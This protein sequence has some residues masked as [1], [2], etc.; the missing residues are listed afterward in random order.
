[1]SDEL[2]T[3]LKHADPVDPDEIRDRPVP[4]EP[5]ERIMA[6]ETDPRKRSRPRVARLVPATAAGAAAIA[7]AAAVLPGG[8]SDT[9]APGAQRALESVAAVAAAHAAPAT[10]GFLYHRLRRAD[11]GAA[12]EPPHPF[13]YRVPVTIEQWAG[14]DGSGRVRTVAHGPELVGPRDA[15]NWRRQGSPPLGSQPSSDERFGPG[16]LDGVGD[17]GGLP[18]TRE[19]PADAGRLA[20]IFRAQAERTDVPV[21]VKTFEYA[22]SVLLQAGSSPDLRAALYEMVAGID[23]VQLAG[24]ARDPLGRTGTGVSIESD[25]S[26]APTRETLIFDPDTSQPLARV[27][28]LLEPQD[29]IEGRLLGYSVLEQSGRVGSVEARP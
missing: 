28:R 25:Y 2:L 18:P 8:G 20:E 24:R 12:P 11:V 5:L 19:L 27:E 7:V 4:R 22:A 10:D 17:E 6:T 29:W 16:G 9:A 3:L 23:G 14:A 26:G 13:A 1:M 21:N 15:E